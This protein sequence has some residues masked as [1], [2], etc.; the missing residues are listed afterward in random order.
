MDKVP[1]SG[2]QR[3]RLR[4]SLG[5]RKCPH[6]RNK[7]ITIIKKE[8]VCMTCGWKP[9]GSEFEVTINGNWSV[10][11]MARSAGDACAE[12]GRLFRL[13]YADWGDLVC[14]APMPPIRSIEAHRK[15]HG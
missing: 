4:W 8:I 5:F 11:V 3:R 7:T 14:E 13:V 12:A 6:C 15:P 10:N 1:S 9:D 2:R